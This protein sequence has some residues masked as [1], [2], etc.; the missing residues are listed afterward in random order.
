MGGVKAIDVAVRMVALVLTEDVVSLHYGKVE[1]AVE[2]N[3]LAILA[4]L[5]P[6]VPDLEDATGPSLLAE[7]PRDSMMLRQRVLAWQRS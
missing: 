6:P 2:A 7:D 1:V 5:G 4:E 3:V